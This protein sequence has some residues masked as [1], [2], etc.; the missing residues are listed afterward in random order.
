MR[1]FAKQLNPTAQ[2]ANE[3][4]RMKLQRA[5]SLLQ[6]LIGE[7]IGLFIA[8]IAV[9]SFL[10]CG[11]ATNHALAART[12]HILTIAPIT[13][14]YT[15]QSV[16]FAV[17]GARCGDGTGDRF[18]RHYR[19]CSSNRPHAS[20][21]QSA[22]LPWKPETGLISFLQPELYQELFAHW[23]REFLPGGR[24]GLSRWCGGRYAWG[25]LEGLR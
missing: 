24:P 10:R 6:L 22:K 17:L 5:L 14:S 11:T 13:F 2:T 7:T 20:Q 1:Q 19:Q 4:N 8:G 25:E 3:G 16:G 12:L 9:P 15:F 18:S 21:E 23:V